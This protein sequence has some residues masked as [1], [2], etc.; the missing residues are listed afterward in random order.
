MDLQCGMAK[1]K[2]LLANSKLVIWHSPISVSGTLIYSIAQIKHLL[3]N[4][5]WFHFSASTVNSCLKYTP[6]QNN[7]LHQPQ[8][9]F[10]VQLKDY[11]NYMRLNISW[12]KSKSWEI[13][14]SSCS[15]L[16][17]DF[18]MSNSQPRSFNNLEVHSLVEKI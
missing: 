13:N 11:R 2:L 18:V 10:H 1:I 6:G 12:R 8:L 16:N 4:S 7:S 3:H 17:L 15:H 5:W 14:I 9:Y